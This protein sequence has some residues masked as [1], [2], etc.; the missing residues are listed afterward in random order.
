VILKK[1]KTVASDLMEYHGTELTLLHKKLGKLDKMYETI[2]FRHWIIGSIVVPNRK[3]AE[4]YGSPP[5]HRAGDR[6][7]NLVVLRRQI[8]E[9]T[10]GE[11]AVSHE[12]K[13]WRR[14]RKEKSNC[15]PESCIG[16]P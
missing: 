9:F 6:S 5:V 8:L 1:S 3:E 15:S 16:V 7:L 4:A 10:D 11:T 14:G 12:R 2:V 13:F